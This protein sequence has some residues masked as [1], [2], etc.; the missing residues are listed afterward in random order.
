MSKGF[1]PVAIAVA[2]LCGSQ[3]RQCSLIILMTIALTGETN[4][5]LTQTQLNLLI[6]WATRAGSEGTMV[7]QKREYRKF[8]ISFM[9]SK[10]YV[11]G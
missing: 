11:V 6:R 9:M 5:P 8:F 2:V 3:V 1:C 10:Q 7:V 4:Q